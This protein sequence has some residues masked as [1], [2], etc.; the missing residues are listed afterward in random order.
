MVWLKQRPSIVTPIVERY[1]Q[2][3]LHLPLVLDT[4]GLEV[5]T[6]QERAAGAYHSRRSTPERSHREGPLRVAIAPGA[7]HAT[8]RWPVARFADVITQLTGQGAQVSL[9]GSAADQAV[10]DAIVSAAGV[11]VHRADGA[12]SLFE[13]ISVLDTCDVLITNDS[14]V[15][16]V[17]AARQIPTIALFGSTVPEL[18]FGPFGV[19]HTIVQHDVACR[20]CSHIGRAR[21]PKGHFLCMEG[22]TT[23]QVLSAVA[24][25]C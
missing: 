1:R 10:C 9:L 11:E 14:G 22:I 16:H 25:M 5:W 8:K 12:S 15:M 21:C 6:P 23:E 13:T 7:H 20:P 4:D 2:P 3:L 24:R 18:G 19:Q 17:G